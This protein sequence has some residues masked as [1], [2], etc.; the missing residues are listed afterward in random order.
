MMSTTEQVVQ[1]TLRLPKEVYERAAQTAVNEQRQLEE[2]L[3]TLVVEGLDAHATVRELFERV[4]EQYRARLSREGKLNQP[5]DKVLE[6]LR[7]L[8][9]QIAR[10]L[11]P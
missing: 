5:S 11:Y 1:V 9:E 2:I 7:N 4:S 3:N 8:R 10:E 6:E